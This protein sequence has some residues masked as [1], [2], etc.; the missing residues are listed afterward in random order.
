MMIATI[1]L[2]VLCTALPSTAQKQVVL[3]GIPLVRVVSTLES[4][5]REVLTE[6]QQNEFQLLITKGPDGAYVWETREH[7]ELVGFQSG[8]HYHFIGSGTGW[9]KVADVQLIRDG[10]I[11]FANA[12]KLESMTEDEFVTIALAKQ[13]IPEALQDAAFI[14]YEVINQGM[15]VGV[16]WGYALEFSP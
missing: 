1:F 16:Y 7:R 11:K 15:L 4:S 2:A 12:N 8:A 3:R 6:S 5:K 14:Y 9:I 13:Y 10:A